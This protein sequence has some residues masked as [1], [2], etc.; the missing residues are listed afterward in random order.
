MSAK[1]K[2]LLSLIIVSAAVF[3][4]TDMVV[5]Q[6]GGPLKWLD[7]FW[8]PMFPVLNTNQKGVHHV[9]NLLICESASEC[10]YMR[11]CR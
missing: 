6:T 3:A 2:M 10:N 11:S 5:L 8:I 9:E 1:R 4:D 7:S